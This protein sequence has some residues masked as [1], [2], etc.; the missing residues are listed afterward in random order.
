MISRAAR[1]YVAGPAAE[2]ARAHAHELVARGY[3]VTTCFWDTGRAAPEQVADRYDQALEI[4]RAYGGYVSVKAPAVGYSLELLA[5]L[6]GRGV[7]VHFDAM[8]PDSV[9]RTRDLIDRLPGPLSTTL[10]SRWRRSDDDAEWAIARGLPVRIVR[11]QW[12]VSDER[13]STDGFL[14][15]VDRLAGRASHVAVATHDTELAAAAL[16]RLRDAGT[17]CEL[18]QL[19]GLPLAPPP[20][21]VYVPFGNGWLPYRLDRRRPRSAWQLARDLARA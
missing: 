16:E 11:G 19:Y 4:A 14:A 20:A 18:E 3:S 6:A 1:C 15:L 21:R 13:D 7:R 9:D 10:P 12:S 17:S 2:D 8:G 5:S